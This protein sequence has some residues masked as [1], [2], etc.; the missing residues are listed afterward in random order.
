[1]PTF[2]SAICQNPKHPRIF[3]SYARNDLDV[4]L[5]LRQQIEP[6]MGEGAVWHDV[7][8]LTGDHWWTDIEES[9]RGQTAVEHIVLL[10]S[11]TALARPVVLDELRL[12]RLEGKT[13]TPVFWSAR[14]G[15][16]APDFAKLPKRLNART[17]IDLSASPAD[18]WRR[19]IARLTE[20]GQGPR[21]PFMAPPMPEGYV[22]RRQADRL[23]FLVCMEYVVAPRA[24]WKGYFKLS[25]VSC[26]VASVV[27]PNISSA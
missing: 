6:E 19:L 4:A 8:N 16:A 18:A 3:L 7:R 5:E 9:I 11:A 21:R 1:M 2:V 10:A 25:L 14:K 17:F 15:F 13:I 23:G 26:P 27:N 12:A 20:S 22:E 24:Y